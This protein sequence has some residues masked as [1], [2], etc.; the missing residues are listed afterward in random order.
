MLLLLFSSL[1][2]TQSLEQDLVFVKEELIQSSVE[3]RAMIRA[4]KEKHYFKALPS[5][6]HGNLS[7]EVTR[8]IELWVDD[9]QWSLMNNDGQLQVCDCIVI[10]AIIN[11]LYSRCLKFVLQTAVIIVLHLVT[12]RVNTGLNWVLLE[13]KTACQILLMNIKLVC[14]I[15]V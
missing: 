14:I 4:F 9:A 6:R 10:I 11:N 3:L 8:R 7:A 12:I 13:L 15:M 1:E 5:G 2:S